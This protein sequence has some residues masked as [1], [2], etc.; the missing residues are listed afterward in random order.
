MTALAANRNTP[1]Q[2]G[3]T[4]D[5]NV[6][7]AAST[8]IYNGALVADNNSGYLV[9]A[10]A[11][12]AL[13]VAGIATEYVDN[14]SGSAGDKNCKVRSNVVARF[15]N[16]AGGDA[17]TVAA[18]GDICYAQDDQ[19]VALT[20]NDMARPIAG[21]VIDVD[22]SGVWVLVGIEAVRGRLIKISKNL[23]HASFTAAATSE[24]VALTGT[25]PAGTMLVGTV[26]I[27]ITTLFSG[28][29]I[30]DCDCDIGYTGNVDAIADGHPVFTGDATGAL[31]PATL[32]VHWTGNVGGLALSFTLLATGDNVVNATAGDVTISCLLVIP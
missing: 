6:P 27:L 13:V 3:P 7:V 15:A 31:S 21:V 17:I 1:Q 28:G 26:E 22:S 10:S 23:T 25:L 2:Y 11:S 19:T 29:S 4:R 20:H 18:R 5:I 32:G 12:A 8:T 24:T 9:A 30:S 16:S 14:S